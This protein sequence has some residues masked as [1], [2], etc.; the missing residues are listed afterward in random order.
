MSLWALLQVPGVIRPELPHHCEP[1]NDFLFRLSST[2]H[3]CIPTNLA[4]ISTLLG[5]LSIVAWLFAQL[6]QIWKNWTLHST[7]GLS[8]FFLGEWLLG[9]L[10][11][12]LG[13]I[14]TRQATWQVVLASYY[15]FVDV[16]LVSQ[17]FWYELLKHGRPLRSVWSRAKEG[18]AYGEGR[19]QQVFDG[20]SI[21]SA[22]TDSLPST[23][24]PIENSRLNPRS[25]PRTIFRTPNFASPPASPS[26]SEPPS[27]SSAMNT[28]SARTIHRLQSAGSPMLSPRTVLYISMLLVVVAQ[29]SPLSTD[30]E[31]KP[32][33]TAPRGSDAEIAGRILSW[34]STLMYLGSRLPQLYKNHMRRSTSGL[35]PTLFAAAFTGNLFYSSSLLTNPCAWDDFGAHGGHGWVG[36]D[37]NNRH[38]W[39]LLA[40]P[41]FFGAAGVLLMDAMVGVQFWWFGEG[42]GKSG[43]EEVV[44]VVEEGLGRRGRGWRWKR[45]EGWMRG[46]APSVSAVATPRGT[47][48]PESV[49]SKRRDGEGESLL[50]EEQGRAYGGV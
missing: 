29:A 16:V 47:P 3:T 34:I 35:S 7:S 24:K 28:P 13:S 30:S 41:F 22:S 37:G 17:W 23:P 19:M 11:N 38:R 5:T 9:D 6:P 27:L 32:A 25:Q 33:S 48:R 42:H 26:G 1:A 20:V 46:W 43:Q 12:L 45:V 40:A 21:Y 2:F 36:K 50:G 4:F 15:C 10:G 14:F 8:I 49:A 39:L 31:H 18:R 44:V